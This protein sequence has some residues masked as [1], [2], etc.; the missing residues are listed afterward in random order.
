MMFW[1]PGGAFIQ[2]AGRPAPWWLP[3][4]AYIAKSLLRTRKVGS[5]HASTS[6]ASGSLRH[7]LRTRGSGDL[8]IL[9]LGGRRR[10]CT[11]TTEERAGKSAREGAR[12][13]RRRY[14]ADSEG[15]R[16]PGAP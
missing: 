14:C 9:K 11:S 3:D 12:R 10:L 4:E 8:P 15:G 6:C 1:L 2:T 7:S 5:P 13:E 16:T